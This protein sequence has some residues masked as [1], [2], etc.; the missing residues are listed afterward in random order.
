[1]SLKFEL[2]IHGVRPGTDPEQLKAT[3]QAVLNGLKDGTTVIRDIA[4]S[5]ARIAKAARA[6]YLAHA[7]HVTERTQ[8]ACDARTDAWHRLLGLCAGD[9]A[10]GVSD[11][12][13]SDAAPPT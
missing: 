7:R 1:M 2:E 8:A 13:S 10:G 4:D 6:Y 11:G 12:P 3:L 5:D 9:V